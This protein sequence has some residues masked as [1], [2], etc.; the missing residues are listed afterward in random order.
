MRE[1]GSGHWLYQ[2][3]DT[4]T[5]DESGLSQEE[6]ERQQLEEAEAEGMIEYTPP[7]KTWKNPAEYCADYSKNRRKV[8]KSGRDHYYYKSENRG[9]SGQHRRDAKKS[10][11][12]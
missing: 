12:N 8:T 10:E 4:W 11:D 1:L 9:S 7:S 6:Q 3:E 5:E 2:S